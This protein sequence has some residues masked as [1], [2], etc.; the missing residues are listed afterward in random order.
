M[1]A[2][3]IYATQ[4]ANTGTKRNWFRTRGARNCCIYSR[5]NCRH[6]EQ[7][8]IDSISISISGR[9]RGFISRD[10]LLELQRLYRQL[11]SRC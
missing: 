4:C 10:Q 2:N 5:E 7:P 1:K 6:A 3:P 11:E 8:Q 9:K